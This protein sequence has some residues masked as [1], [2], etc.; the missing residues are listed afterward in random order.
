MN[1][2]P[3]NSSG[4][5]MKKESMAQVESRRPF[6][7]SLTLTSPVT[8]GKSNHMPVHSPPNHSFTQF[9]H[10]TNI[11]SFTEIMFHLDLEGQVK[12]CHGQ[13]CIQV[14]GGGMTW[15]KNILALSLTTWF[16]DLGKLL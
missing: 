3:I 2:E 4:L 1:T 5:L 8:L 10:S 13:R 12:A 15:Y 9:V 6:E 14:S 16:S 7:R 11:F